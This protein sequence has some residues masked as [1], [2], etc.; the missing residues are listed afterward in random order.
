MHRGETQVDRQPQVQVKAASALHAPNASRPGIPALELAKPLGAPRQ[1]G[2]S[3]ALR[4]RP[5]MLWNIIDSSP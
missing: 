5:N 3:T 2:M 1:L 4:A